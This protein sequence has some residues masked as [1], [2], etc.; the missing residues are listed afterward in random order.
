MPNPALATFARV[1]STFSLSFGA[2]SFFHHLVLLVGWLLCNGPAGHCVT[3]ALVAAGVS[4]SLDGW[5]FHRFFSRARWT[6]DR[7]GLTVTG[8]LRSHVG[9][10]RLVIDDT[11]CR[12]KGAHVFGAAMHVDPVT[13]TDKHKN[14]SRGHC[15]VILSLVFSVPWSPHPWAVPIL[16]RLYR[17][18]GD[19]LPKKTA[20]AR[21]ML[22]VFLAWVG[23][24]VPVRVLLDSG[25]MVRD[26]VHGLPKNVVVFGAIRTNSALFAPL[27][28]PTGRR[29]KGDRLPT[30]AQMA[31]DGQRWTKVNVTLY[32]RECIK[33]VRSHAAQWW[34]VFGE[35]AG[36]LVVVREDSQKV[37]AFFCTD[38][39]LS[40]TE[41][42]VG[43]S[44]RWP[45]EVW[46]RTA[47]QWLGFDESPA[48]SQLAVLRTAPWVGLQTG[49]L[50]VWF[51]RVWRSGVVSLPVRPWYEHKEGLSLADVVRT[52]QRT[53]GGV[54]DV[55]AWAKAIVQREAW[56]FEGALEVEKTEEKQ[57]PRE[58]VFPMVA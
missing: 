38:P 49:V 29:R 20:L 27:T 55:A 1:L 19:D 50:V 7:L 16:F 13:S 58:V 18:K 47:K 9:S 15:W 52:A 57:A 36:R 43:Y 23:P 21:E 22:N 11:L 14:F 45:Q 5:P 4:G 56:V 54:A 17:G 39:N 51:W 3:E 34:H 48:R 42:L 12:H 53:L 40:A 31:T 8:L 33:S 10:W 25:Y 2:V 26:V 44:F 41:V 46:H 24:G 37:R 6:P 30:P 28:V 32:G 35:A